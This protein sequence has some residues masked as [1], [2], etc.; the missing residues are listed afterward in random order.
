MLPQKQQKGI[1]QIILEGNSNR[2]L[3]RKYGNMSLDK[4]LEA[5]PPGLARLSKL[6]GDDK[7]EKVTG[8]LIQEASA[9]FDSPFNEEISLDLSVEVKTAY[10]FLS[11][12]DLFVCLQE[13]KRKSIYGKL[14][15][16]KLLEQIDKYAEKRINRAAEINYNKHLALKETKDNHGTTHFV[17]VSRRIAEKKRIK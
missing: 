13:L 11:M 4:V 6:H 14:T 8:I 12:E 1:M 16:H 10:P 17:D 5:K 3:V 7:V 15:P 9:Y 2:Q